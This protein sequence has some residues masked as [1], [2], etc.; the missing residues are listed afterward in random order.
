M[1]YAFSEGVRDKKKKQVKYGKNLCL[2]IVQQGPKIHLISII[3]EKEL[4]RFAVYE[5]KFQQ[6]S[7]VFP[8]KEREKKATIQNLSSKNK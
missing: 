6:S 8:M 5:D 1:F 4:N 2:L 3:F 7:N